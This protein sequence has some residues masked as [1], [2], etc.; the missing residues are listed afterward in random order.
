M[1]C[2]LGFLDTPESAEARNK[3]LFRDLDDNWVQI[4]A[5]SSS[6]SQTFSLLKVVLD[7]FQQDRPAYA[8]MAQRLAAMIG[9]SGK[10]GNIRPLIRQAATGSNENN[11][12]QASVL[13]G[14]AQ[15]LERNK[16][17]SSLIKNELG[18]LIKICF[19]HPSAPVRNASLQLLKVIGIED[20]SQV[21]KAIDKAVF[22]AKD[23]SLS[24]EKRIEAIQFLTLDDLAP[25]ATL[26]KTLIIPQEQ[27][28]VQRAALKTL[29][30][31][32]DHTVTNYVLEQW[33]ALTPE[34]RE[35]AINTFLVAPD[36]ISLLLE[37]IDSNKIQK[38]SL[39]FHQRGWL[40]TQSDEKLRTR[41]RAMFAQNEEKKVN[42]EYQGALHLKGDVIKGKIIYEQ[43]CAICHQV[44]G[45][46]GVSFGPDLGTVHNWQPEG[47]MANILAPD[48]SIAAGYEFWAV[49]L[50]S[51]ESLQGIIS[52]ETPGAITLKNAGTM[53][54]TISRKDIK[55][56][57]TL[58]ISVMPAGFEKNIDQQQM[59]DLLAFLRQNN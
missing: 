50:N 55:S 24:D 53:E 11:G 48:L 4:A 33:P 51:G 46:L 31:I 19:E 21:K 59:A 32:P 8:S 58:N 40:M 47:I 36:R 2:T 34:I 37:A 44:R 57:K 29:S 15:G 6:S 18:D 43:N 26:L 7:N 3:L 13:E 38:A 20:K 5:L 14:L 16:L 49:E 9:A 52:S 56:L 23:K 12:W 1:L 28:A 25:H 17:P 22:I 42:K 35:A 54:K 27:P 30:L 41:A 45:T 10:P 39:S